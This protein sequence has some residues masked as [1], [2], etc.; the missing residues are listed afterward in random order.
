MSLSEEVTA[1]KLS[2]DRYGMIATA[3]VPMQA[4]KW[5]VRVVS[6]DGVRVKIGG[7]TL[8]DRWTL[9]APTE[10]VAEFTVTDAAPVPM[11]IE[12]FQIEG[13]AALSV[14]FEWVSVVVPE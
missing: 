11:E 3:A 7:Q 4:G 12:F 14:R 9:H 1:A 6:D 13:H 10:D 8:V 5:R 2:P